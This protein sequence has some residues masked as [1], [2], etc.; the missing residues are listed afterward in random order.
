MNRVLLSGVIFLSLASGCTS[1]PASPTHNAAQ[2]VSPI[3]SSTAPG[4]RKF[5]IAAGDARVTLNE[6]SRQANLQIL[7]DFAAL[8]GRQTHAVA[9]ML[10]PAE[11]LKSM[12]TDTGLSAQDVNERTLAI[13]PDR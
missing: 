2:P 5:D 9:G 1:H 6:F 13:T 11:A 3:V 7:F 10:P 4:L 12:L 8:R